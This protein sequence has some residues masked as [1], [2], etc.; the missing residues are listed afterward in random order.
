M[1]F[2]LLNI[3]IKYFKSKDTMTMDMYN[4]EIYKSGLSNI[5]SEYKGTL[6]GDLD[7]N[8]RKIKEVQFHLD[9][10]NKSINESI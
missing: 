9:I 5:L 7:I 8:K 10:L 6:E 4:T 1:K 2:K 3:I